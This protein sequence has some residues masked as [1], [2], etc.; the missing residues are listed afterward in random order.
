MKKNKN[1]KIRNYFA[2][3]KYRPF[4][5]NDNLWVSLPLFQFASTHYY[6]MNTRER[7]KNRNVC[8]IFV[9]IL[10]KMRKHL[11]E[12]IHLVVLF[13][14]HRMFKL[15]QFSCNSHS[16]DNEKENEWCWRW[17][18]GRYHVFAGQTAFFYFSQLNNWI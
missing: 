5:I 6:I 8:I 17:G 18:G 13:L 15:K 10:N 11:F 1:Q 2:N 14:W 4:H 9:K 7:E 3:Q 16:E 12:S